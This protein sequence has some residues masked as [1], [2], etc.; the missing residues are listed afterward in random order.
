[1]A[2][3][4]NLDIFD[5]RLLDLVQRGADVPSEALADRIGLSAS[6]VQKRLKRLRAEGVII[7]TVALV[8]ATKAGRPGFFIAA[9]EVERGSPEM[10]ARVRRW[11]AGEEAVQQ[12]YFVTGTSDFIL[13]VTA[14]DVVDYETVMARL[15]ADNPNVKRYTT[16]VVLDASKRSLAIPVLD[17]AKS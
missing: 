7:S 14:R 15:L 10:L 11:L 9:L 8:D 5:R 1:M 16:Q 4:R 3:S 17:E 6:A 2:S 13:I 12:V